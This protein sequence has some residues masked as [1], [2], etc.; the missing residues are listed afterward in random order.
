[1][2]FELATAQPDLQLSWEELTLAGWGDGPRQGT[3]MVRVSNALDEFLAPALLSVE[4]VAP[5]ALIEA[6][7]QHPPGLPLPVTFW[8]AHEPSAVDSAAGFTYEV[9]FGD[10]N[11]L[12]LQQQPES[13]RLEHVY[14]SAGTYQI[15]LTVTDKDGDSTSTQHD[16][17]IGQVVQQGDD[18]LILGTA[19]SDRIIVSAANGQGL[20][21]VR[22]NQESFGPLEARGRI[23][24]YAGSGDDMVTI[25]S[26]VRNQAGQPVAVEFHGEE[27]D[28]YLAGGLGHDR[29]FGGPGRDRLFGADGDDYLLGGAGRDQLDGGLGSDILSGGDDDDQLTGGYGN[30]LLL[31]GTGRDYLFGQQDHDV[32]IGGA[33]LDSLRGDTGDDLLI[34]GQASLVTETV[35][36]SAL[37][38]ILV[39]WATLRPA[40]P[41]GL[42]VLLLD[43]AR[44]DLR[45]DAG[46]DL[47]HQADE[48]RLL[49]FRTSDGDQLLP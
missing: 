47:F 48:D 38:A 34:G 11:T 25:S 40:V 49:D 45:G 22:I 6:A 15:T 42:G 19:L 43:E 44:D 24:V 37:R 28:D 32:L 21:L 1:G 30:D 27:G 3:I 2:V 35:Q 18:L 41:A 26:N 8:A 39:E 13:V 46:G 4:N 16:V 20:V 12:V 17:R 5:T 14:S 7:S 36:E 10:G 23:L 33:D 29:L 9:D 31:G